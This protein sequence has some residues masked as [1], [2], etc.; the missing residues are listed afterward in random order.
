MNFSEGDVLYVRID[1]KTGSEQETK[2]DG[3]DSME[4]LQRLA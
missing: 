4:Y 1:Y 2:Q 3:M